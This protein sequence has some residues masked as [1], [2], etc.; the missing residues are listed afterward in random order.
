M[1]NDKCQIVYY[2]DWSNRIVMFTGTEEKCIEVYQKN[3]E[4]CEER[5]AIIESYYKER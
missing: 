3:I 2:N 5:D 4:K 1:K